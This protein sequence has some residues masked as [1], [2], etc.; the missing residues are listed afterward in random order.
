MQFR[1]TGEVVSNSFGPSDGCSLDGSRK[2]SIHS[3]NCIRVR[4]T[5][6]H[7]FSI[8]IPSGKN[9]L[10]SQT[11]NSK[12]V[13]N[14]PTG[15]LCLFMGRMGRRADSSQLPRTDGSRGNGRPATPERHT[16]SSSIF[17]QRWEN[18]LGHYWPTLNVYGC[19]N[20]LR[21]SSAIIWPSCSWLGFS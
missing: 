21:Y 6:D 18:I 14:Q 7:V 17:V 2:M 3:S 4:F 10:A 12:R 20:G 11:D 9:L 13:W 19:S 16:R 15:L 8:K 1:M 5:E